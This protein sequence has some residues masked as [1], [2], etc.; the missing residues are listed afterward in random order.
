MKITMKPRLLQVK[1]TLMAFSTP[2]H[3]AR[4]DNM[5]DFNAELAKRI[6]KMSSEIPSKYNSN[7]GGWQ[8]DREILTKLGEP[9]GSQLAQMFIDNVRAAVG[10]VVEMTEPEPARISIDAWANV[11]QKGNSNALHIHPGCPW[12]GSYYVA[13]EPNC[14]GEIYFQDPRTTALMNN[15]PLNPFN[16]T[17]HV[18]IKPEPGMMLI[19]P[20]FVFHGVKPYLGNSPR[21]MIAFNLR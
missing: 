10:S 15:H 17:N 3:Q 1:N 5:A 9:Y 12:S 13:M 11:N 16:A 8:S 7:D 4:Y 19:F 14:A 18:S 21:I 6:L 2:I 20:S